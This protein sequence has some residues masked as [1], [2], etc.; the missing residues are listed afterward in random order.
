M[1]AAHSQVFDDS[2]FWKYLSSFRSNG[3]SYLVH[4]VGEHS[5]D[6]LS[7]EFYGPLFRPDE[8][9]NGLDYSGFPG[10]VTTQ[11]G[12]DFPF[13]CFEAYVL[14]DHRFSIGSGYVIHC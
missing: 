4:L 7:I 9:Q 6:L 14:K 5:L 8:P 10:T 1:K 12:R 13:F 2:H 11:K 3:N